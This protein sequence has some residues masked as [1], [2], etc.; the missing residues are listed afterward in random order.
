[1]HPESGKVWKWEEAHLD[2]VFQRLG[3]NL[4]KPGP[5]AHRR[6][7]QEDRDELKRIFDITGATKR[8]EL[9]DQISMDIARKE[10]LTEEE[11]FMK[12]FTET[13]MDH[14]NNK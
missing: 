14:L 13:H 3:A 1:M 8:Y 7:P 10:G 12:V 2:D 11:Y 6:V 9:I 4:D 5:G